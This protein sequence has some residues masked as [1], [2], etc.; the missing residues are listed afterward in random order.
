[1]NNI[2][3]YKHYKDNKIIVIFNNIKSRALSGY[4]TFQAM[5]FEGADRY[6]GFLIKENSLKIYYSKVKPCELN[7]DQ[8]KVFNYISC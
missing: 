6:K 8:R 1:M 3:L 5:G 4:S 7:S 2:T